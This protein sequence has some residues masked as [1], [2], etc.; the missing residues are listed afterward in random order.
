MDGSFLVQG[1]GLL[2][3]GCIMPLKWIEYGPYGFGMLWVN[4][5]KIPVCSIFYLLKGD[6]KP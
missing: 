5:S 3:S 2:G 4:H 1:L 6:Y